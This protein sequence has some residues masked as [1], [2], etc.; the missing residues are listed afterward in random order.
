MENGKIGVGLYGKNGHQ[1]TAEEIVRAGA[2]P[3]AA[4]GTAMEGA[5]EKETLGELLA[6]P[7]VDLVSVCAPMRSEQAKA[8]RSALLAGKHVYAEKPCVMTAEDWEE[9]MSLAEERGLVFCEMAG[10]FLD[11]LYRRAAEVVKSGALG[12]IVQIT[13]RKSYPYADWRPQ[14][15]NADG[16]L[17]LQNAL[18]GLRFI[19]HIAGERAARVRARQTALGNPG[20]GDLQMAAF[21]D[22]DLE[23]GG[24]ASVT[25][26]Y[27]N[28]PSTGVWGNEELI[29]FGT[30]AFLRTDA[31][32]NRVE[33]YGKDSVQTFPPLEGPGLLEVLVSCLAKGEPLPFSV[34]ELAR[35]TRLAI[36]A[37]DALLQSAAE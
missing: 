32:E 2:F 17:I 16:G 18:Y 1:L 9:L 20:K 5:R 4:C 29:L 19:E 23:S 14:D 26:N 3:A 10:T 11:P 12:Q 25:A 13:A 6:D 33:L 7:R 28:Q 31:R 22:V 21:L 37:R 15:E 8:V 36:E 35:P 30:N 34:R 27:L 24:I